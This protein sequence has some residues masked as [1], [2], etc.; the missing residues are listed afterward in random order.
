MCCH[1]VV[2]VESKNRLLQGLDM[3]KAHGC[4][5]QIVVQTK[6]KTKPK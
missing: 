1:F 6:P 4:E 3:V 2:G 5:M